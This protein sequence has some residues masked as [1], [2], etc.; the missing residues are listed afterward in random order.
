MNLE[1]TLIKYGSCPLA[2]IPNGKVICTYLNGML[3]ADSGIKTDMLGEDALN[4]IYAVTDPAKQ[5]LILSKAFSVIRDNNTYKNT[6]LGFSTGIVIM[7][8]VL[9]TNVLTGSEQVSKESTDVLKL[10]VQGTFE[11]LKMII[12]Q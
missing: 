11:V 4:K 8:I 10:I 7:G 2:E 6:V 3:G 1:E 9:A 5:T 12:A